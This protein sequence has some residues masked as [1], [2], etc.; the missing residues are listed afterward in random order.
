MEALEFIAGH[1]DAILRELGAALGVPKSTLTGLIDRLEKQG[2]VERVIRAG[3]RR[4]FGLALTERGRKA[5][6]VY[7]DYESTSWSG[8]LRSLGS[9][10]RQAEFLDQMAVMVKALQASSG[11]DR[12]HD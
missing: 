5:Y 11:G 9:R 7:L 12:R 10:E 6:A 4:S 3:D 8:I 2:L 1:P